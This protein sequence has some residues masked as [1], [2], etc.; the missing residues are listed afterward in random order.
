MQAWRHHT[1][2]RPIQNERILKHCCQIEI[3]LLLVL[4]N[5]GRAGPI[6]TTDSAIGFFTN[7]ASRLLESELKLPLNHIQLYPTNQY[8]PAVHRLLQVSANL[9]NA[10]TDHSL[11]F[12]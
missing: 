4:S 6:V 9:Y 2:N 10:A 11:G 5:Q 7:L 1:A 8:T 12:T 3:C